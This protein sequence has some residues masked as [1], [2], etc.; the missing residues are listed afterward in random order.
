[1]EGNLLNQ[2]A[3]DILTVM[4]EAKFQQLMDSL[5][6]D[7]MSPV[8]KMLGDLQNGESLPNTKN[9]QRPDSIGQTDLPARNLHQ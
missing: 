3:I 2:R 9:G 4:A 1:M 8:E 5:Q 7:Y 6:Q